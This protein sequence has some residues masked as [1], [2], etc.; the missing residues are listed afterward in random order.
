MDG[1]NRYALGEGTERTFNGDPWLYVWS[2]NGERGDKRVKE[3]S[4][5]AAKARKGAHKRA[6]DANGVGCSCSALLLHGCGGYGCSWRTFRGGGEG[7]EAALPVYTF[8]PLT[9]CT[10]IF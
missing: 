10:K 7:G 9:A 2:M 4:C 8:H 3:R 6:E 5:L 1:N